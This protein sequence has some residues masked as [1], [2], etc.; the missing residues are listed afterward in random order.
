METWHISV[1]ERLK[2]RIRYYLSTSLILEPL[3]IEKKNLH[4]VCVVINII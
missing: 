2:K 1:Y 4:S 3:K